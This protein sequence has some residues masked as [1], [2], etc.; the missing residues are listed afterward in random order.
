M[1][2]FPPRW[3]LVLAAAL[4]YPLSVMAAWPEKPIKMVVPYSAGSLGDTVTRLLADGMRERLGV[5]VVENKPG[6]GGNLGTQAVTQAAPDG[7]TFV[8]GATNN[9][10][11]NQYL[12]KSLRFDPLKALDP[13]TVL[14]EVPSVVFV[15]SQ[16]G[17]RGLADLTALAKANAGKFNYGSSGAGTMPHVTGELINKA[18]GLGFVHVPFKGSPEVMTALLSNEVQMYVVGPAVGL[19][20]VKT[21]KLRALA[22]SGSARLAVLPET[23]T[24]QEVGLGKVKAGNWWGVA[25]PRHTPRDIVNRFHAALRDALMQ[26]AMQARLQEMGMTPV[27]S[28][29]DA[30]SRRLNEEARYW[31]GALQG[32]GISLD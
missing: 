4:A 32:M 19:P 9:F 11:I 16:T 1:N 22:V 31:Q 7:Y 12:Y 15:N 18:L 3:A 14:V 27:G 8:V 17:V 25:A 24:F 28:T 21:G 2:I 5:V 10:V 23:P 26:P 29:P 13:V 6:A 20:Y 30:T